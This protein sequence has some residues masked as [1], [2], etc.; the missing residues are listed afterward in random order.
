[1]TTAIRRVVTGHDRNGKAVVLSDWSC[2][3]VI[4]FSAGQDST[5]VWLNERTPA[6][7]SDDDPTSRYAALPPPA[8]GAAFRIVEFPPTTPERIAQL[9]RTDVFADEH[10][11]PG[12]QA[13]A[14]PMMHRTES[15]DYV[16]IMSGEIDMLM[17]D[18]EVHMKAGDVMVQQGTNHAWVNRSG[19]PCIVAFAMIGAQR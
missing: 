16:V 7:F 5:H 4:H 10:V 12:A 1:M 8:K 11:T 6:E 3:K 14:H 9:T 13:R 17:D 2:P 15:I 18:S 19:K